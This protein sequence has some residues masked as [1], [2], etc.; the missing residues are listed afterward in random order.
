MKKR[1]LTLQVLSI[2]MMFGL[3]AMDVPEKKQKAQDDELE[4]RSVI[5]SNNP[6]K[7][8]GWLLMSIRSGNIDRVRAL[9]DAGA[10]VNFTNRSSDGD[11]DIPL[12]WAALNGWTEIV[13][14]LIDRGADVELCGEMLLKDAE[15]GYLARV[16]GLLNAGVRV[17]FANYYGETALFRAAIKG[18]QE[19]VHL[20]IAW[21]L[22]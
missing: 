21:V 12:H 11:T 10:D 7:L 3:N 2:A 18:K 1:I 15:K 20:L 16:Q 22:D 14:L 8:G 9:L 5:N 6:W 17:N 13:R 19:I 4:F